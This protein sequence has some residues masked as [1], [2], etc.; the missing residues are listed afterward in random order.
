M[1]TTICFPPS[2]TPGLGKSPYDSE[3]TVPQSG[4]LGIAVGVKRARRK[5]K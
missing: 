2:L 4:N 1:E 5:L 3:G